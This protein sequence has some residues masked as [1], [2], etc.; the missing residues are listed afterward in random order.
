VK[1]NIIPADAA[2][3]DSESLSVLTKLAKPLLLNQLRRIRHG[4][5]RVIDGKS[6]ETFGRAS[7][8][9]PCDVTIRVRSARFYP[10]VVFLGTLG[11]GEAYIKGYWH[12]DNL[13]EL[14]RLMLANHE[15]LNGVDSGWSRLSAPLRKAAHRLNR[16]DKTT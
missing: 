12:C 7:A 4:R 3:A 8:G 1:Q 2:L 14:V 15:L 11:A 6:K 9:E 10:Q 5:L 13:T 16:N